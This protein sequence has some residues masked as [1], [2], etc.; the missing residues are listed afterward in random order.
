MVEIAVQTRGQVRREDPRRGPRRSAHRPVTLWPYIQSSRKRTRAAAAAREVRFLVSKPSTANGGFPNVVV[1]AVEAIPRRS[2][3]TPTA[4]GRPL[5]TGGKAASAVSETSSSPRDL[6]VKIG[7]HLVEPVDD[8][9][10]GWTCDRMSYV[11]R[12]SKVPRSQNG[13]SIGA[14]EVGPGPFRVVIGTGLGGGEKIVEP[15]T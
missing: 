13:D 3:L 1:T 11:Q 4:R 8:H 15:M 10:A 2:A 12:M 9:W 14:P 7:G 6:P 5:L